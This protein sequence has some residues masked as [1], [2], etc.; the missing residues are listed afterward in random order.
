MQSS[1]SIAVNSSNTVD[2][3]SNSVYRYNFPSGG[4]QFTKGCKIALQS[5]NMYYSTPNITTAN[6]NNSFSYIW[7]GVTTTVNIPS[8]YY[9]ISDLNSYLQSIM[10]AN[11][12]YLID[13]NGDYV[14][15]L[16]MTTNATLYAIQLNAYPIPTAAQA[17]VL[18][19]TAPGGWG[20]YPAAAETPQF[21]I[22]ATNI[23]NIFGINA[24]TYPAVVQATTY[25]KTSDFTPQVSPLQS[26]FVLCSLV[27]NKYGV[28][29]TVLF[30]FSPTV[31]YGSII[32]ILP[33]SLV[34]SDIQVGNYT[35]IDI[36]FV[37]QDFNRL[38]ILDN[39]ISLLL[40]IAPPA[41]G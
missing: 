10:I 27:N 11:N 36:S 32:S 17:G 4:V 30:N 1:F 39:K 34:Y 28:P 33:P 38:N 7:Q 31:S 2:G 14:Y 40:A 8:G 18:G 26:I 5:L 19:Y 24:G 29:N 37:D 41:D 13:T 12:H 21:V 23:Q 3:T 16:E 9:Q 22:P 15:F 35:S 6:S 20:G 25:S